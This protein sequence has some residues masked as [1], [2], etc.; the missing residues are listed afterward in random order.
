M[1][2]TLVMSTSFVFKNLKKHHLRFHAS[3]YIKEQVS[4][5]LSTAEVGLN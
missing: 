3:L 1:E 4:H 2:T 5:F